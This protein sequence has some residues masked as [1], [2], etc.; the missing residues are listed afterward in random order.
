M[1]EN[2]KIIKAESKSDDRSPSLTLERPE[3]KQVRAWRAENLKLKEIQERCKAEGIIA[4]SGR[5]P[6][7]ETLHKWC[8]GI[9]VDI[10]R[11]P[12]SQPRASKRR[13]EKRPQNK[14]FAEL[15][16]SLRAEGLSFDKIA[17]Q[18]NEAGYTTSKGKPLS[19]TQIIRTWKQIKPD[20]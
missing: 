20:D 7:L 8:T 13:I 12:I 19:K 15:M 5:T 1:E 4:R 16:I 14:G 18:V 9:K 2:L 3:V 10:Q 6:T 17:D 11:A